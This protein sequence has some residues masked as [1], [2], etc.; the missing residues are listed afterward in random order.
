MQ[1]PRGAHPGVGSG[2]RSRAPSARSVAVS[3]RTGVV[4]LARSYVGYR[5]RPGGLSDFGRR[6]GYHSPEIPWSG[7][8]VDCIFRDAGV[9]IPSV[10][11]PPSG[12][13]EFINSRRW[14]SRPEPGDIAFLVTS[15]LES[16]PF[17]VSSVGV[18]V[19]TDA[20][21]IESTC[22]VAEVV[23]GEVVLR[24]RWKYELLGFGRPNYRPAREVKMQTGPILV[25]PRRVRVGARG[26]HVMNVQLALVRVVDLTGYAPGVFDAS[27]QR[28]FARWQRILGH[29][30]PDANGV[31]TDASLRALGER[32]KI[33]RVSQ[34]S[35]N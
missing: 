16:D 15:S 7:A 12:L 26:R 3:R 23:S 18:V 11:Y 5:S 28:A 35:E 29:V 17:S 33:F 8:F 10:V 34:E 9:V 31:P 27:T 21:K 13:A 2:K 32:S 30:G 14:R 19:N 6:V 22:V 1:D 24:V 25:D 20:W 4:E